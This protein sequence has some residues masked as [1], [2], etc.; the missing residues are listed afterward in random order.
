MV[1]SSPKSQSAGTVSYYTMSWLWHMAKLFYYTVLVKKNSQY[2]LLLKIKIN[3]E[4]AILYGIVVLEEDVK[5]GSRWDLHTG[6]TEVKLKKPGP[7][8][9]VN[10]RLAGHRLEELDLTLASSLRS[11]IKMTFMD[12]PTLSNSM[13]L[14]QKFIMLTCLFVNPFLCKPFIALISALT[15]E[16]EQTTFNKRILPPQGM[17]CSKLAANRI[18]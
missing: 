9:S 1:L 5:S 8:I 14:T 12:S 11:L 18:C 15:K 3:P 7:N 6:R 13:I 16:K 2:V 10:F 4:L 17:I